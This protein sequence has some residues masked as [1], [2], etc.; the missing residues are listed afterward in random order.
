MRQKTIYEYYS[1]FNQQAP[2]YFRA[3]FRVYWR[4]NLGNRRNST[5]ALDIQNLTAQEN[6]AY[7]FYDPYTNQIETKFQLTTIPNFSWRLEF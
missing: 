6:V 2:D 3:D 5:F 7:H 4:K 1:G